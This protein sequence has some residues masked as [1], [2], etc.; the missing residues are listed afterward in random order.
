MVISE[1]KDF[2]VANVGSLENMF[3]LIKHVFS[4]QLGSGIDRLHNEW[5]LFDLKTRIDAFT[6]AKSGKHHMSKMVCED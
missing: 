3:T 5:L 1:D 2:P 4:S 6:F